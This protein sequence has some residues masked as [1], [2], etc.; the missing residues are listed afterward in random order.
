MMPLRTNNC[1]LAVNANSL[2]G[3]SSVLIQVGRTQASQ[4]FDAELELLY[5]GMTDLL[6][7][8]I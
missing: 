3:I 4:L 2:F 8:G 5:E 7:W 1:D 6:A